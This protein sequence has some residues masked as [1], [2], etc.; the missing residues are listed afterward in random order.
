MDP[1][2]PKL[3][4]ISE[5]GTALFSSSWEAY[6]SRHQTQIAETEDYY[7]D[8][9]ETASLLSNKSMSRRLLPQFRL[10]KQR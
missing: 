5:S 7:K 10:P 9:T 3:R 2:L 8:R 1:S 4:L 6:N